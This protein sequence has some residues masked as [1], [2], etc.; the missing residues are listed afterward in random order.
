MRLKRF[1]FSQPGQPPE[2][3]DLVELD[4][5][6]SHQAI[7]VLRLTEGVKIELTG[8]WGLALGSIEEINLK[9]LPTVRVKILSP[10]KNTEETVGPTLALALIRGPRFDWAV[11][12]ATE[13]GVS[14]LVP[15]ITARSHPLPQGEAKKTRWLRLSQEARKQCGRPGPMDICEPLPLEEWLLAGLP[16]EKI[17][18]DPKG[19]LLTNEFHPSVALLIGPEG[20]LTEDEKQSA[21]QVGFQPFSLGSITLRAETAALAALARLIR[22]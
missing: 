20:G 5:E 10:F 3:D 6:Q 13:L 2:P 16:D 1:F 22:R 18:L 15:L 11:E 21:R 7:F 17:L 4:S 9:P 19:P 12:K 8:P 14:S